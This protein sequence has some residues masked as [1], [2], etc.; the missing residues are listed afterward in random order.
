MTREPNE[1]TGKTRLSMPEL[2]EIIRRRAQSSM[3]NVAELMDLS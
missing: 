2:E 1:P 3:K